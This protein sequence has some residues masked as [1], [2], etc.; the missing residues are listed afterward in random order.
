MAANKDS[1]AQ[2]QTSLADSAGTDSANSTQSKVDELLKKNSFFHLRSLASP[3][4][5]RTTTT[6]DAGGELIE[7]NLLKAIESTVDDKIASVVSEYIDLIKD[8]QSVIQAQSKR[9]QDLEAQ[10]SSAPARSQIPQPEIAHIFQLHDNKDQEF[11]SNSVRLSGVK[12]SVNTGESTDSIVLKISAEIGADIKPDDI[13]YSHFVTKPDAVKGREMIVKFTRRNVKVQFISKR[14]KL[15]D[16]QSKFR[17]V[18]IN[19][20]LTR[21]RYQLLKKLVI[22]KKSEHSPIH[23]CWSYNGNIFYK[24]SETDK[25]VRIH[26]HL[27]FDPTTDL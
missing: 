1:L 17:T 23:S 4:R 14:K 10:L 2:R 18:Y 27:S 22:L 7:P 13:D 8:Q 12:E 5:R 16:A 15:R 25:P 11:R 3:K 20:D 6:E 21:D 19:E 26:N 9:I 24:K